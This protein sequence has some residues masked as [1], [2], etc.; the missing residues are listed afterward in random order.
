MYFFNDRLNSPQKIYYQPV[1]QSR[2]IIE[3]FLASFFV[4]NF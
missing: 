4:C 2:V 1:F 3:S